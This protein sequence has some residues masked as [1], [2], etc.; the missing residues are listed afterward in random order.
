LGDQVSIDEVL[1]IRVVG[2]KLPSEGCL[3]STIRDRN[4]LKLHEVSILPNLSAF[5]PIKAG[6]KTGFE[7]SA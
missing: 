3:A 1:A 7:E 5:V 6:Q 4:D 2:K